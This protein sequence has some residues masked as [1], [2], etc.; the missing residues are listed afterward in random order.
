MFASL[1]GFADAGRLVSSG[2]LGLAG[3]DPGVFGLWRAAGLFGSRL[4]FW[5]WGG[6]AGLFA[7]AAE[8]PEF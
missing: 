3:T 2:G 5:V 7:G 8:L 1:I 6:L 4:R